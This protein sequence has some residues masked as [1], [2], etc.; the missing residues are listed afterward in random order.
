MVSS[1]EKTETFLKQ[2]EAR[3]ESNYISPLLVSRTY[4]S[5]TYSPKEM[6]NLRSGH[7]EKLSSKTEHD[8]GHKIGSHFIW[9][10]PS[11]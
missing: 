2:H 7:V 5:F 6:W 3:N 9:R 4:D 11:S 1:E 10:D 8:P